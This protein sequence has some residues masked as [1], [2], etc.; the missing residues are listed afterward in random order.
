MLSSTAQVRTL[1]LLNNPPNRQ[2]MD[3]GK[4]T[5]PRLKTLLTIAMLCSVKQTG[6]DCGVYAGD[7]C[8]FASACIF[9]FFFFIFFLYFSFVFGA[10]CKCMSLNY[11]HLCGLLDQICIVFDYFW[12]NQGCLPQWFSVKWPAQGAG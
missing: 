11:V 10:W 7:A 12:V 2:H 1:T 8:H 4:P 3:K 9:F 5:T 6:G